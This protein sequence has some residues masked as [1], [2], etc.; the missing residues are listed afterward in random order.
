MPPS[1]YLNSNSQID[2]GRDY[3]LSIKLSSSRRFRSDME[4]ILVFIRFDIA[5]TFGVHVSQD[6]YFQYDGAGIAYLRVREKHLPYRDLTTRTPRLQRD[7]DLGSFL[8]Q[9]L[10][11]GASGAE[12]GGASTGRECRQGDKT[13]TALTLQFQ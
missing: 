4:R 5:S 3:F 10:A 13:E 8:M 6:H 12:E 11:A 7:Q 1:V 9:E 2:H